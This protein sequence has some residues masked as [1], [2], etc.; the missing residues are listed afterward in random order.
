MK[1]V[2]PFLGEI[3]LHQLGEKSKHY[4]GETI[5]EIIYI[6]DY[7]NYYIKTIDLNSHE[8]DFQIITKDLFER[9]SE[10]SKTIKNQKP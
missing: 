8:D 1:Y 5:I 3:E 2:S 10:L 6:D 7:G 9:L 4:L